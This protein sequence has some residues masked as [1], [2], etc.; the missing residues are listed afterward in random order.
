ML[1]LT[2][3]LIFRGFFPSATYSTQQYPWLGTVLVSYFIVCAGW[4]PWHFWRRGVFSG[5]KTFV[6]IP[7]ENIVKFNGK[8]LCKVDDIDTIDLLIWDPKIPYRTLSVVLK[9]GRKVIIDRIGLW[10]LKE[11]HQLFEM[12]QLIAEFLNMHVMK[13]FE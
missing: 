12:S 11:E 13:R 1:C 6:L 5:K 3:Y 10:T 8:R 4:V 2:L 7:D 9:D